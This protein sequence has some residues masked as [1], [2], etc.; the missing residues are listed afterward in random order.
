MTR[1]NRVVSAVVLGG[2]LTL[3][4]A[5][6]R[7]GT[8]EGVIHVQT[9]EK[10]GELVYY[11]KG[12]RMRTEFQGGE[13]KGHTPPYGI[14]DWENKTMLSVMPDRRMYMTINLKERISPAKRDD[15]TVTKT[16]RTQTIAGYRCEEWLVKS[17]HDESEVWVSDV[18]RFAGFSDNWNRSRMSPWEREMANKG[19]FPFRV[20][21]LEKG[22]EQ[23]IMEVVKVEKKG[24]S[25]SLFHVP[26]GYSQFKMP[27]LQDLMNGKRPQ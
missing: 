19:Y 13:F 15:Y 25:D 18:G 20:V 1:C 6:A 16:G 21:E 8:F 4:A 3:S 12:H 5:Q 24:L 26:A 10:K 11:L 23:P 22:K 2:V 7:A 14:M 17:K 9:R 27:S